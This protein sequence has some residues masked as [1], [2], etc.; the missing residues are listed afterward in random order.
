[1]TTIP[2]AL[3]RLSRSKFRSRF[4][5]TEAYLAQARELGAE[6]L[7]EHAAAFVRQKLVP[8]FPA[9]DGKQTPMRGHP[10]FLAMHGCAM[11]CRGCMKKWWHVPEGVELTPLQQERIVNFLMAWLEQ[12][13]GSPEKAGR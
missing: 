9:N 3:E 11:C 4:R 13:M 5:L 1:M 2:D 8:A 10:V 12:Q 7:R 6:K